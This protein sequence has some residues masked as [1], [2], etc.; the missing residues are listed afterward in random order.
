MGHITGTWE[1]VW[2]YLKKLPYK[3]DSTGVTLLKRNNE[4][5]KFH[6]NIHAIINIADKSNRLR[7][8]KMPIIC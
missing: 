1:A 8:T 2:Q 5:K 7:P 6:K 3:S 4:I